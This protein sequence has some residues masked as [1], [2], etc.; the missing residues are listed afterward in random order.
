[1]DCINQSTNQIRIIMHEILIILVII[2]IVGFQFKIFFD[3]KTKI[4]LFKEIIPEGENFETVKVFIPESQIKD[5]KT[6]YILE[7][8]QKFQQPIGEQKSIEI[9][10]IPEEVEKTVK[11]N[12]VEYS[13]PEPVLQL[14]AEEA[15]DYESMIWVSKGNEEKKIKLKFLKSNEMLG[16]NRI[17]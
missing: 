13:Q 1:M 10:A 15:I 9:N 17:Q 14:F 7:N 2:A 12:P 3:A 8:L 5:I 4:S 11:N 6:D 16:W